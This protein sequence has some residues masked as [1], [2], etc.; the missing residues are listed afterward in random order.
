MS[1]NEGD[2]R[3]YILVIDLKIPPARTDE[4]RHKTQHG[5]KKGIGKQSARTAA[6]KTSVRPNVA[7]VFE[8]DDEGE[9]T[10][11]IAV[12]DKWIVA[13][14]FS[15]EQWA[16]DAEMVTYFEDVIGAYLGA[17]PSALKNKIGCERKTQAEIH[18]MISDDPEGWSEQ[19]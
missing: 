5:L 17:P 2:L 10:N 6:G 1:W 11:I 16:D 4:H 7:T 3:D 13:G 14:D 18:Q 9:V 15:D 12:A 8:Y 19:V